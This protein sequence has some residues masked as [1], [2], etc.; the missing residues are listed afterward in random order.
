M[1]QKIFTAKK[2]M[3]Y[4]K[5]INESNDLTMRT[6]KVEENKKSDGNGS[7]G[8]DRGSRGGHGGTGHGASR[9]TPSGTRG[10]GSNTNDGDGREPSI[11]Q[12][13]STKFIPTCAICHKEDH[14]TFRCSDLKNHSK[15]DLIAKSICEKCL[16]RSNGKIARRTIG[17]KGSDL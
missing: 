17:A 11:S 10:H 15:E 6:S 13:N 14:P 2:F 1:E 7:R 9:G 8:L 4:I 5:K 12:Q 16:R 3:K